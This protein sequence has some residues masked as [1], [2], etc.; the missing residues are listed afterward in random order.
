M[1]YEDHTNTV[2]ASLVAMVEEGDTG[3]WVM[4]WHT[5]GFA[6]HLRARNATT[7]TGYRGANVIALAVAG[8]DRGF[9]TGEWATYRQWQSVD[10]Q[11]RK[12]ERATQIVKW[13]PIHRESDA[14][15]HSGLAADTDGRR[16]VPRVYSVFNAHQLEGHL[17]TEPP[18]AAGVP[19]VWVQ[20]VGAEV[21]YGGDRAYY[22]PT[23][24]RIYVPAV[25]QF[26]D[27]V[28]YWATLIHEHVHWTGHHSRLNRDLSGP[29]GSPEYANEE[30]I[31]ELGAAIACALLGITAQPRADH[32]A[33][34]GHWLAILQ[35]DPKAL[36]RSAAAAQRA[37]DL[38][39][40]LATPTN[41][42]ADALD[43]D[44]V[45]A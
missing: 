24:D 13:I 19:A 8:I 32:A 11:V 25:D 40:Q 6:D 16:L 10:A 30:L 14:P 31:A 21:V 5:H 42:D 26:D 7:D 9:P 23:S 3:Q 28:A 12:G 36:F 37:V 20:A 22:T 27:S 34:L 41:R 43:V 44:A 15:G 29:F 18:P 38:L 33:Y 39:D 17:P 35:D 2:T 4:P 45:P 1:N